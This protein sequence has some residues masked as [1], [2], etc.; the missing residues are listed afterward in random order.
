MEVVYSHV[1]SMVD[2]FKLVWR[3]IEVALDNNK[4]H[5]P[6]THEENVRRCY[7]PSY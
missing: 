4:G 2:V 5:E 7:T 1:D 6:E 3:C